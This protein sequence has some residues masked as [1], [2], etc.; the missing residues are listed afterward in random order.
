M[1]IMP[2]GTLTPIAE[3]IASLIAGSKGKTIKSCFGQSVFRFRA[4]VGSS[5]APGMLKSLSP[6]RLPSNEMCASPASSRIRT[7]NKRRWSITFQN[8]A[9]LFTASSLLAARFPRWQAFGLQAW[10]TSRLC[11]LFDPQLP[12]R[13]QRPFQHIFTHNR[14]PDMRRSILSP[15]PVHG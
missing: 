3:I 6:C 14:Q 11:V 5:D 8:L 9:C 2:F 1:W 13:S 7:S 15:S 12:R 4:S 10:A